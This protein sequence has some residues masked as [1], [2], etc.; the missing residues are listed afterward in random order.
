M[1]GVI[2]D[3]FTGA[4]DVAVAFR[5]AGLRSMVVF[6]AGAATE[7]P[8]NDVTVVALKTRTVAAA[9]AVGQ[10]LHALEWLRQRGATQIFFKYCSTFDSRPQGNIGPVADALADALDAPRVVFVPASP[11]HLR[12]QYMGHLFVDG[13]LLSDSPMKDHPLTPMTQSHLPTVLGQQTSRDIGLIELADVR[14]GPRRIVE[15]LNGTQR[16]STPY[17]LVDA[18]DGADLLDIGAA[19][20]DEI[21]VTGAAGL[22]G[23]LGAAY[24]RRL[25]ADSTPTLAELALAADGPGAV[26]AG[27][28]S[29]RTLQQIDYMKTAGHPWLQLNA[30]Q[31][32]DAKGL[33]HDALAWYDGHEPASGPLI[34]SSVPPTDLQRSREQLGSE[35]V[36]EL[37][38]SAMGLIAQGLTDRG[39]TR[40]VVAGGETS[41]A[42]VTA[43]GITGGIIGEEEAVGVPWIHATDRRLSLLLKSGN[44]G[45]RQLLSRAV[46]AVTR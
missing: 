30:A 8:D 39:V 27:S 38:E 6:S 31:S 17:V 45:D 29:A 14:R 43:L 18:L 1:I 28:C 13:V 4:T 3:D 2:A 16:R 25:T 23:G 42:V 7:L 12:T 21:L 40:L 9:E 35:S 34:Y 36:S 5:R 20:L 10:S 19:C 46:A 37:F 33:A 41:G 24:S 11:E 26:L 15:R 44:F 32:Q 22:A